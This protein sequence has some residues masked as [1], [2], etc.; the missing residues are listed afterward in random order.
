MVEEEKKEEDDEV[1]WKR[2]ERGKER[3]KGREN[4]KATEL[5]LVRKNPRP[6]Q[7]H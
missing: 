5:L 4:G 1:G 7:S 2:K 3:E 6:G